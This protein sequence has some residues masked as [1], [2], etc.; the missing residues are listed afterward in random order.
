[1]PMEYL[2]P[3]LPKFEGED[4]NKIKQVIRLGFYTFL[5]RNRALFRASCHVP[6]KIRP[7]F[8]WAILCL[9]FISA[10]LFTL[11]GFN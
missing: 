3:D 11:S 8:I 6:S 1:M 2:H 4:L 9:F 7:Y 5:T 10:G